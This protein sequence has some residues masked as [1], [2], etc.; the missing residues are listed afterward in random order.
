MD[1]RSYSRCYPF[2]RARAF[3]KLAIRMGNALPGAQRK[4]VVLEQDPL[5]WRLEHVVDIR[6]RFIAEG[7]DPGVN[8]DQLSQLVQLVLPDPTHDVVEEVLWQRFF[9]AAHKIPEDAPNEV[10]I[11]EFFA[12]LAVVCLAAFEEKAAFAVDLF[13]FNGVGSLSYVEC[14]VMLS[15]FLSGTICFVRRG[16]SPSDEKLE[17]HVR[18]AYETIGKQPHERLT[19]E[20]LLEYYSVRIIELCEARGMDECDTPMVFLLCYDLVNMSMLDDGPSTKAVVLN[21][22]DIG[23]D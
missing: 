13:D 17:A 15:T 2:K 14:I 5:T 22:E 19:K 23:F 16:A 4:L 1:R 20:E 12:G 7:W 8:R 6:K 11:F 10:N 9:D 18:H 21:S 3:A